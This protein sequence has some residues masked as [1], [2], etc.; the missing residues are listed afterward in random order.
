M[1]FL[2]IAVLFL[3]L[4]L[5]LMIWAFRFVRETTGASVPL[6]HRWQKGVDELGVDAAD[7]MGKPALEEGVTVVSAEE[8]SF[9][10]RPH[11]D[12]VAGI[13]AVDQSEQLGLLADVQQEIKSVCALLA[14]KDGSKEDFFLMFEF[15]RTK[16]PKM[17]GHPA[18]LELRPFIRERVPFHLSDEELDGLWS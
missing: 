6:E 7:L 4:A 12:P 18:L 2:P 8:F 11:I 5:V 15:V 14:Q 9:V 1:E 10:Q 16:Y 13:A 17:A 3:G